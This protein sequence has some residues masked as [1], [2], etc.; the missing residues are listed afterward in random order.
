MTLS[1][2]LMLSRICGVSPKAAQIA[3]SE[4][5][6]AI[7]YSSCPGLSAVKAAVDEGDYIAAK[8]ELVKYY[9]GR[10]GSL[11]FGIDRSDE[12]YGMAVLPM[13]NILTGPYEFD[14]WQ[15]EFTVTDK[16]YK[17]YEVDVT[18]R[19]SQELANGNVSFMLFAG[20]K[21]EFA[22]NVSSRESDSA[23]A[24]LVTYSNG[25]GEKTVRII[26][27]NDTYISSANTGKK[28]GSESTLIIKEDGAGSSP[29]G[30]S[31][32]RTYINFP[33]AEAA[34]S[35]ILSAKLVVSAA[36]DA[37]CTTGDK[38]VLIINTGDTTWSENSLT[39]SGTS[40]SIYSYQNA[41]VPIWNAG[42]PNRDSEYDNVTA[43]FWFGRPMAYEYLSYLEDPEEYNRTHP[44]SDKYPGEAF[45]PKLV[46]LMS[47]FA[48][49][50]NHGWP[51]TLETGE[52]LNRWVDI[53]DALLPTGV[54]DERP[55]DFYKIISFM[56]GDCKY[57]NSLS[58]TNGSYWWS[59]WRIVANAGFFKGTEYLC[60]LKDHDAFRAK[61]EGNVE[62]T[63]DLLYNGDMSFAEAGPAYA[64][65][66][67]ELFGDC[68]I[69]AEKAGDPM[70]PEFIEKL[71]GAARYAVHS[72]Y[73]NGYDSNTGDS[74]YRSKMPL[75]EN[76]AG[77]LD[78]PV[79]NAY[80]N[81][82]SSYTDDLSVIY[83]DANSVYMRSGW[84]PKDNTYVS[85]VNN[86][87]DGH[88]HP[89]SNQILMYAYGD[90]LLVDSGRYSYSSTNSIYND[91]RTAAAH[92]TVEAVGISMGAH[93]AAAHKITPWA[94]NAMFSFAASV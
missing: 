22:V 74:N 75:F 77:F 9:K 39:W 91:L 16:E 42:A 30:A 64:E 19:V 29:T 38:D 62:Y 31:T 69:A 63:M 72:F 34:N 25:S 49:Q 43:R 40:G 87:S 54:F 10:S 50:M 71:R 5:F 73:P 76:L 36:Y 8:K 1:L 23:P 82:D 12:N 58:I 47:A 7:D 79:L 93:S 80:V 94:D 33:L 13:R 88:Y 59:N 68:A 85:F 57:I 37:A 60:E 17:E 11:G 67:A 92:N 81:G 46:D 45:G 21:Q 32:F 86:P 14:M 44:Y 90:P 41:Q 15:G 26:A 4:F 24:L 48:S 18:E 56:Y 6:S 83:P 53:V 70:K 55:D 3:E 35:D 28:Y 61:A 52:R 51:R 78:D 66:C 65:W 27:D 84:D 20:D 2:G 89:D